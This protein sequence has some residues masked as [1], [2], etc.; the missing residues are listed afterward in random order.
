MKCFFCKATIR[1]V[2]AAIDAGWI[3][4]FFFAGC[5]IPE[6]VCP[7]CV[8]ARLVDDGEGEF[9]QMDPMTCEPF[10]GGI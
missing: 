9:D 5:E 8:N 1:G 10:V 3:P 6:P 2:H 4:S 7:H